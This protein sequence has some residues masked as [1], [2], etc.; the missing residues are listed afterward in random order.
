MDANDTQAR[1]DELR[2]R[3]EELTEAELDE[4]V[5]LE[6]ELEDGGIVLQLTSQQIDD[7][8]HSA[9]IRPSLKTGRVAD[10]TYQFIFKSYV[11]FLYE[12]GI[13]SDGPDRAYLFRE[14]VDRFFDEH[15]SERNMEPKQ[16]KK[17]RTALT[18]YARHIEYFP[19]N[20]NGEKFDVDSASVQHVLN[21]SAS[22]FLIDYETSNRDAHEGIV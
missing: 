8:A 3:M 17:Y 4:L 16:F 15:V 10:R 20:D 21:R 22:S 1:V 13:A 7:Y 5:E 18:W 2:A 11:K 19:G 6:A 9:A 14:G 12:R